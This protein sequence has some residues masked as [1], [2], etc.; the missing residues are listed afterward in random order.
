MWNWLYKEKIESV[1]ETFEYRVIEKKHPSGKS[2]FVGESTEC[3]ERT[4]LTTYPQPIRPVVAS[5]SSEIGFGYRPQPIVY[6]LM[7][8]KSAEGY[9]AYSGTKYEY[10]KFSDPCQVKEIICRIR[11]EAKTRR[12]NESYRKVVSEGGCNSGCK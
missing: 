2:Y 12:E 11:A 1:R 5:G 7:N 3:G 10:Y 4:M 8:I 9:A 6:K